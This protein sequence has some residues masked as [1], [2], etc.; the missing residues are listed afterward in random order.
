MRDSFFPSAIKNYCNWV[1][2]IELVAR[3]LL[4]LHDTC[5]GV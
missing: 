5:R 2:Y 1:I 4:D 3:Y